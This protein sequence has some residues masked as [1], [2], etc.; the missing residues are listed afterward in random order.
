MSSS[1]NKSPTVRRRADSNQNSEEN[2]QSTTGGEQRYNSS[3]PSANE[4]SRELTTSMKILTETIDRCSPNKLMSDVIALMLVLCIVFALCISFFAY[5]FRE[6]K[7]LLG[8][9]D[10]VISNLKS[11][12]DYE[13]KEQQEA[14]NSKIEILGNEVKN[15]EIKKNNLLNEVKNL[16]KDVENLQNKVSEKENTIK[17]LA[18]QSNA[19]KGRAIR[20]I[21]EL[22]TENDILRKRIQD[23]KCWLF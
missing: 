19:S 6:N 8:E 11:S 15:L 12:K 16:Q 18:A 21:E 23:G 9:K 22:K 5:M 14:S 17:E 1:T 13:L 4:M 20:R 2:L 7:N 10:I 3:T